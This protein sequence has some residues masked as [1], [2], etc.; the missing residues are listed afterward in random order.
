MARTVAVGSDLLVFFGDDQ[1]ADIFHHLRIKI[2]PRRSSN[3]FGFSLVI[4]SKL[5]KFLNE[6]PHFHFIRLKIM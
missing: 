1:H 4:F 2:M 6:I 5:N 3:L